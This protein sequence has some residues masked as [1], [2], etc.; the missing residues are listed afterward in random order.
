MPT[1]YVKKP[2]EEHKKPGRK[3]DNIP[4]ETIDKVID[5]RTNRYHLK[6]IGATTGL[7][8]W[9]IRNILDKANIK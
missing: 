5:M 9:K 8:R 7:S 6:E 1:K 3:P 2:I 4:Q